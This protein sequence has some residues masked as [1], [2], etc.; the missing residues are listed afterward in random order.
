MKLNSCQATIKEA[1]KNTIIKKYQ[2]ITSKYKSFNTINN[3][4]QVNR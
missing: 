1:I 2:E 3:K 4:N